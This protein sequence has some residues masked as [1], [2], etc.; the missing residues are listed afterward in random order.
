[1]GDMKCMRIFSAVAAGML[2]CSCTQSP[3]NLWRD[4]PVS[5]VTLAEPLLMQSKLTKEIAA[6]RSAPANKEKLACS[7]AQLSAVHSH[8][9]FYKEAAQEADE[10]TKLIPI[11][12][13]DKKTH[14][15]FLIRR[16]MAWR[17]FNAAIL[18]AI[19][20]A[21]IGFSVD[22]LQRAW[23]RYPGELL[24]EIE[25]EKIDD[26]DKAQV[27]N[28]LALMWSGQTLVTRPS[29]TLAIGQRR[30]WT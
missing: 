5:E 6:L 17:Q 27:K 25:S 16:A 3:Q 30:L 24:S 18:P 28:D 9:G 2:V 19:P 14:T 11:T 15:G 22:D 10:A 29:Q 23:A 20:D 4:V 8:I 1:M 21:T 12:D 13:S 26:Q 7:L